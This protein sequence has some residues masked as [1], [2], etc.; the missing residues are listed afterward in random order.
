MKGGLI[1][2]CLGQ[3]VSFQAM[4]DAMEQSVE[5][6]FEIVQ[7]VMYKLLYYTIQLEELS[8]IEHN[9]L[10]LQDMNHLEIFHSEVIGARVCGQLFFSAVQLK[11]WHGLLE[12]VID[13]VVKEGAAVEY[14]ATRSHGT[15]GF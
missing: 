2:V 12:D 13:D 9:W 15:A 1:T 5:D 3:S 4:L 6:E 7:A 14:D 10:A 11:T 8:N